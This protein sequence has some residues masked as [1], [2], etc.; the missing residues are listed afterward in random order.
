MLNMPT[1]GKKGIALMS[2]YAP[3]STATEE[4]IDDVYESLSSV[5]VKRKSRF[6]VRI[7]GDFNG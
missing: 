1:K 4:E 7:G 6:Q 5:L 3:T 2:V